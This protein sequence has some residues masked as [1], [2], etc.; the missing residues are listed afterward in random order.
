MFQFPTDPALHS[1]WMSAIPRKD[2]TPNENHRVCEKHFNDHDFETTSTD[3]RESR[4]ESRL[5]QILQKKRLKSTAIPSVFPECPKYFTKS[6]TVPRSSNST[7]DSRRSF[8]NNR[9]ENLIRESIEEDSFDSLDA[10]RSKLSDSSSHPL[11]TNIVKVDHQSCLIFMYVSVSNIE[12]MAPVH[13]AT[14]IVDESMSVRV[15]VLSSKLANS[16]FRHIFSGDKVK[17]ISQ[18]CNVIAYT[19]NL[20]EKHLDN[21]SSSQYLE[22]AASFLETFLDCESQSDDPEFEMYHLVN[23]VIEQLRLCQVPKNARKYS[24]KTLA[25]SFLWQITSASLYNKLR[26]IFILP[27]MTTLRSLS[28]GSAVETCSID[29]E[30]LQ[31]R[32]SFLDDREKIVTLM[33]DEVY[34][35]QRVELSNGQFVGYTSDGIPAKTVL[36]FMIQ[37][38]CS[39]YKDVVC[40]IPV[41]RLNSDILYNEFMSV[42]RQIDSLFRVVAVSTDN[43]VINRSFF[44]RLCGGNQIF[45]FINH[46]IRAEA[47]LF[48][49]F[50]FT[51]NLKNIFNNFVNKT[52]MTLPDGHRDILNVD[53]VCNASFLHV[54]KL[55]SKEENLP[56]KIAHA[57]KKGSLNPVNISRTSPQHALSIFHESTVNALRF[58]DETGW[59]QTAA[60]VQIIVNVWKIVSLKNPSKGFHKRDPMCEPF[61]NLSDS[62]VLY[63]RRVTNLFE[64][65]KKSRRPGLTDETFLACI[66]TMKALPMLADYL[67]KMHGFSYVLLGKFCSDP[68]EARFGCYRQMN[69][70]NFFMSIKQLLES[71]KKIRVLGQIQQKLIST[72]MHDDSFLIVKPDALCESK[73]L[74]DFLSPELLD[75]DNLLE[76]D[77][78]IIYYVAGYIGRSVARQFKCSECKILLIANDSVDECPPF[79]IP[80]GSSQLFEMANRGGLAEPSDL[81]FLISA[82][83]YLSYAV[84]FDNDVSKSRFL[85]EQNHRSLFVK[86]TSD[87]MM[88]KFCNISTRCKSNHIAVDHILTRMYNCLSKNELKRVNTKDESASITKKCR[89]LQSDF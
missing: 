2:F 35:A 9:I 42:I 45:P 53:G 48:I 4:R 38:S 85:S 68:I 40:L 12:L 33:I 19:K 59:R 23:F 73:W 34:T 24:C 22:L 80:L 63:L 6:P 15:F 57:L 60:Y 25:L 89:K 14:V 27:S 61:R 30:Y 55:Y 82:I 17:T 69:G 26:D 72:V 51:H 49:L 50:D 86:A 58:Y 75:L 83:G 18:L 84:I 3:S 64:D 70:G 67:I 11:P 20:S 8:E 36:T 47:K 56:L 10:L 54:K 71:E 65:W 88:R 81:C 1:R 76:N 16:N 21:N 13:K 62:H 32:S 79:T 74:V 28:R 52:K 29:L 31:R 37:S 39:K 66:Q 87:V 5:S 7:A 46:P 41:F 44:K 43:H 78:N 77:V